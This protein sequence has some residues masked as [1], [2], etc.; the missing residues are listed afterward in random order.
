MKNIV[1]IGFMGSGK[2]TIG[3][4]V[5]KENK[6]QFIDTDDYIE[7]M[8]GKSVKYIFETYGEEYFREIEK[9]AILEIH[10]IMPVVIST[11]GGIV[12]QEINMNL[13]KINGVVFFIYAPIEKIV[14]NISTDSKIRPLLNKKDWITEAKD[15]MKKRS[16]LYYKYADFIIDSTNKDAMSC[17]KEIVR[18]YNNLKGN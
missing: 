3:K 5:A 18:I 14:S 4:I 6:M 16:F 1:L 9:K 7:K 8:S 17:A 15:L 10:K 2:T 13:L 12:L 11:G